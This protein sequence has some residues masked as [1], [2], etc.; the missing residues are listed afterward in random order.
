MSNSPW[1]SY[2][3]VPLGSKKP[4]ASDERSAVAG[5]LNEVMRGREQLDKYLNGALREYFEIQS[6][7]SGYRNIITHALTPSDRPETIEERL[8]RLAREAQSRRPAAP[9]RKP[10]S[11]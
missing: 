10:R 1:S 11:R 7:S 8:S 2:G 5:V 4:D 6:G 9:L 3:R